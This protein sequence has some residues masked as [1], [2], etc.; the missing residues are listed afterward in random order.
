VG[1]AGEWFGGRFDTYVLD[2]RGRGLSEHGSHL[3]YS[4]EACAADS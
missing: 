4:P 2:V 1:F 3:D